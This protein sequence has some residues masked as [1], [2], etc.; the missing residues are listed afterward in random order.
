[1]VT[2]RRYL[3]EGTPAPQPAA[4]AGAPRPG[5]GTVFVNDIDLAD[6]VWAASWQ[7]GPRVADFDGRSYEEALTWARAQPAARHVI[8][9]RERDDYVDLDRIGDGDGT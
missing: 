9:M 1:M 5:H 3:P 8:F 4:Q 2:V 7:D 6:N